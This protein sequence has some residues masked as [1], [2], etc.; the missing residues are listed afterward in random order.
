MAVTTAQGIKNA[1]VLVVIDVSLSMQATDVKPT[2]LDGA[3]QARS[4][5]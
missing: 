2:R 1:T 4:T 3:K 5:S